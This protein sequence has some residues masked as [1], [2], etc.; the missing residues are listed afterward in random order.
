MNYYFNSIYAVCYQLFC[1]Y[2]PLYIHLCR[3]FCLNLIRRLYSHNYII[4]LDPSSYEQFIAE[5]L[6][7]KT[8]VNPEFIKQLTT[9][10][11]PY[12]NQIKKDIITYIV[13]RPQRQEPL[14]RIPQRPPTQIICDTKPAVPAF[15][16]DA[17]LR[18][19]TLGAGGIHIISA[20]PMDIDIDL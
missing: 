3:V 6:D 10:V 19:P 8:T 18:P 1:Q 2:Y 13:N 17:Y 12:L 14:L 4:K 11:T 16:Y 9:T 20:K 15:N 5:C 7:S